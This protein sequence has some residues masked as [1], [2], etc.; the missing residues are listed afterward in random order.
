M[1]LYWE[2][3]RR[4]LWPFTYGLFR[5]RRHGMENIPR[6]GAT[7]IV[8]NHLSTKDPPLVGMAALPRFVHFMAKAELFRRPAI[9]RVLRGVGAFPVERGTGDRDAIRFA[10]DLLGRGDAM[11]MFPEGTRSRD[12][13]LRPFFSGAGMLALEPGVTVIPAAIWGSQARLA[14]VQ[15]VFGAPI[16]L[17]DITGG[18]KSERVRRA[19]RRLAQSVADLVPR[20]GGPHQTV[21][22]GA[23][24]LD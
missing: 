21:P 10:R 23:P 16:D 1:T 8:C 2:V 5:L 20:V 22:E 9:A 19:T 14:R 13:A 15:V 6:A 4:L 12:G 18:S 7:L 24:S 17:S 11:I 3:G